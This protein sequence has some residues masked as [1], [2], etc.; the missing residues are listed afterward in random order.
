MK[1]A[2]I[3]IIGITVL[4]FS[5]TVTNFSMAAQADEPIAKTSIEAVQTQGVKSEISK[6]SI[7]S[8]E[9][10]DILEKANGKS[11]ISSE[12]IKTPSKK[13]EVSSETSK[14]SSEKSDVPSE[15]S[16]ASSEK[17]EVPSESIKTSSEKSEVQSKNIKTP[18][19]N[20]EIPKLKD[21]NGQALSESAN[22]QNPLKLPEVTSNLGQESN[23]Y[24]IVLVHGFMGFGRDELLGYKYWGG[25]VDLQEKLIKSGHQT[26]TATVGSVSSNWDR[27][28]ELYA[29]IVGGTVDYGEAHA[30]KYGHNRYGRRYEGIY[31]G[32]SD[33][34]KIHLIGHS[35]G[36]Q[37]IRTLTQLL[38]EGSKEETN[39]KQKNISPLFDGGKHWIRSVTTISTPNDGTTLS[40]FIPGGEF[41]STA[42]G[43]LGTVT[44]NND[45]SSYLYD[46]KLDQWG[47]KKEDYESQNDYINKV[48][49]S[50]IWNKTKDI[51]TYDLSTYGAQELNKWVKAQPDVYYF[52]WVTQAT[53]ES[54]I[55]DHSLPQIGRMNPLFYGTST[56]MGRYTRNEEG[57]PIINKEWFPN[58][59]VVNAISQDG[60][61]LGSTD[62]IEKYNGKA[63]IGQ[64]N[65]MPTVINTDHM[66]IV[67][68]FGNVKAWYI[69]YAEQ[70]SSLP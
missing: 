19:E 55:A 9:G 13:S 44:G 40:D 42:F 59:G 69:D 26:Y 70:L 14:T 68:T 54:L 47:L 50:N 23:D 65:R 49:G 67:G 35:M 20:I 31:K 22:E 66:D 37:T 24:P 61:K 2:L 60:P 33:K 10:T 16:K 62:I 39:Y 53:T 38:S 1:K 45:L 18:P 29:Y 34:N 21:N 48:L 58:D 7:H 25:T 4:A 3:K 12:T 17:S 41:L 15:T 5:M 51:A 8:R 6:E 57:L 30:K 52:S 32:I 64:W 46:F 27:A 11:E 56:L 63:K 28:C 36:G 43:A